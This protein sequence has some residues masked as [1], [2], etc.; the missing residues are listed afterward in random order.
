MLEMSASSTIEARKS[1]VANHMVD[2]QRDSDCSPVLDA[3][4][5]LS[6]SE[7]LVPA[8]GGQFEHVV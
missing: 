6:A 5:S 7:I 8:G 4:F 3:S 1:Y 2:K